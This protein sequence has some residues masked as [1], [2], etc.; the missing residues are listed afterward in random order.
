MCKRVLDLLEADYLSLRETV[1]KRATV[2]KFGVNTGSGNHRGCY[3][4]EVRVNNAKLRNMII[5]G[6]RNR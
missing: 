5:A 3:G 2:I 6:F 1:I 4:I